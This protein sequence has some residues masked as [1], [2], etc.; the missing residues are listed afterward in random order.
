MGAEGVSRQTVH[1]R[2]TSVNHR[3]APK[4]ES[5][6]SLPRSRQT[7]GFRPG[8][9]GSDGSTAGLAGLTRRVGW[10]GVNLGGACSYAGCVDVDRLSTNDVSAIL[11]RYGVEVRPGLGHRGAFQPVFYY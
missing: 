3:A 2:G 4:T 10:A 9:R 5:R 1:R 7:A 11:R 6:R 8:V